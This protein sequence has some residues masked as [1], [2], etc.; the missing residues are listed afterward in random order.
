MESGFALLN[1][2]DGS[3][4]RLQTVESDLPTTRLNDGRVGRSG[5][6]I[7]GGMDEAA[8]KQPISAVYRLDPDQQIHRIIDAVHISNI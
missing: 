2:I 6:F 8:N 5:R 4:E 7:C 1:S 3:L